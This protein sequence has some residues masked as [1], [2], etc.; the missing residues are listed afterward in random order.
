[1][2]IALIVQEKESLNWNLYNCSP[3]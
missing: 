3:R 2:F 1:L